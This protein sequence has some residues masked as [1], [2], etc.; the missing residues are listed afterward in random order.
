MGARRPHL[1]L[2]LLQPAAR[3]LKRG[4]SVGQNFTRRGFLVRS[5]VSNLRRRRVVVARQV[6]VYLK[7]TFET[8]S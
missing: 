4:D 2:R 8:K 6:V 7:G 5:L 1:A 3:H